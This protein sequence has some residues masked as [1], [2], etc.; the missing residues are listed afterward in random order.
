MFNVFREA[1]ILYDS[2]DSTPYY[3]YRVAQIIA[4]E[5][6]HMWFGNLV[7]CFWWSNAWLNE[8]FANYFQDYI[9]AFVSIA[10]KFGQICMFYLITLIYLHYIYINTIYFT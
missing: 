1:L 5:T 7:T 4:H 8:G 2:E 3:K 6:T 10:C 9:T